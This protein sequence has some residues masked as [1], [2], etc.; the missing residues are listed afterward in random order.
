VKERRLYPLIRRI[1]K[2]K[3][4]KISSEVSESGRTVNIQREGSG[5]SRSGKRAKSIFKFRPWGCKVGE[6]TVGSRVL[7]GK[8]LT[9]VSGVLKYAW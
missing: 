1:W 8:K 5:K 4:E 9:V 2:G 6:G 3:R 7:V